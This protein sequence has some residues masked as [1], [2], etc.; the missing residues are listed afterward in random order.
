MQ[1]AR[2]AAERGHDV[3]LLGKEAQLGGALSAA[4]APPFKKDMER[5]LQWATRTTTAMPNI[6]VRL[7]TEATAEVVTAEA[8]DVV[9]V[10]VGGAPAVPPVPGI[11]RENVVWAAEVGE[12]GA[13]IGPTVLVVGAGLTGCETALHLAE[14]G[15]HVTIIDTLPLDRIALDVHPI[16]RTALLDMLQSAL[17]EIKTETTLTA[18]TDSGAIVSDRHGTKT[19]VPCD[20]VVVATGTL[21]QLELVRRF[22]GLPGEVHVIGDCGR[23]SGNLQHAVADG[24]F[25]AMDI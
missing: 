16:S 25:A 20:C 9:I 3:I 6:D 18:V 13:G 10:A 21:P 1:A 22:E 2:T 5:Y 19:E 4:S 8:P 15:R 23:E 14:M 17:V 7:S 11:D 24:F 12:D